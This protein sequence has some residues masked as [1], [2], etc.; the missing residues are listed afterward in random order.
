MTHTGSTDTEGNYLAP[1]PWGVWVPWTLKENGVDK[2]DERDWK[3]TKEVP[4]PDRPGETK[5]VYITEAVEL[6][7][8]WEFTGD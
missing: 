1:E 7:N 3:A 6:K 5:Q 2:A 8:P 4:D